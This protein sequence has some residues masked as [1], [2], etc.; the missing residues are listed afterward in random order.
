MGFRRFWA[1]E[2]QEAGFM[3]LLES[4][5][6][7]FRELLA[8]DS[9]SIDFGVAR[10]AQPSASQ[11]KAAL[12]AAPAAPADLIL[13]GKAPVE[14]SAMPFATSLLGPLSGGAFAILYQPET[15]SLASGIPI[16][17]EKREIL[18]G[19][20]EDADLTSGHEDQ[21]I[22][23]GA[24]G[25]VNLAG[26]AAG[27]EQII[28]M[29]G[30]DYG[31]TSTDGDVA[32]GELLTVLAAPLGS[33]DSLD[34]DG[35]AEHDGR[36]ALIGGRG[37]DHLTGGDGA[38]LLYGGGGGDTLT[39]GAGADVFHYDSASESTGS[40]YDTLAGFDFAQDRIDLPVAVTGL[41]S[42]VRQGALS[43][44][45]FDSDLAAAF[46]AGALGAGHAA[47]FTPT[48]GDLAGQTF[49]IVDGNGQAGYQAGQDFVFHMTAPP[50]PDA[51]GVAFFV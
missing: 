10:S 46:G 33:G 35:S 14:D 47:F 8:G 30:S 27:H 45:S 28:L 25:A 38:D 48:N 20:P 39:G 1:N 12:A 6:R 22:I 15:G 21:L 7:A 44:A 17:A 40:G 36:F 34:F 51:G 32:A 50:P 4:R 23:G 42:A 31:L 9:T 41:D 3:R 19:G 43:T 13:L 29:P 18:K 26:A 24:I 11:A 2:E 5:I 37:G 16:D 49:L